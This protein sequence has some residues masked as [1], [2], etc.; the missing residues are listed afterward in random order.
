MEKTARARQR[1][2]AARLDLRLAGVFRAAHISVIDRRGAQAYKAFVQQVEAEA[3]EEA[4]APT[5]ERAARL[6][7][8]TKLKKMGAKH[9]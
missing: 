6:S 4:A 9:G 2:D 1:R 7:L 8:I 5:D 3:N